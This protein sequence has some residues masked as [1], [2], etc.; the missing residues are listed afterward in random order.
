MQNLINFDRKDKDEKKWITDKVV[1]DYCKE[2]LAPQD[3][4]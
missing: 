3:K 1:N 2:Y 4:T